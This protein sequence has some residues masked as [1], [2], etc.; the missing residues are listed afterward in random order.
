MN[1]DSDIVQ[2]LGFWSK[3]GRPSSARKPGLNKS[4][5]LRLCELLSK[6]MKAKKT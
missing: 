6:D 1:D 4:E 5:I 3:K 2:P